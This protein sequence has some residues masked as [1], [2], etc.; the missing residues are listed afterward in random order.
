[1]LKLIKGLPPDV[2]GVEA[3]GK[4]T[5][6]DY[7]KV[8]I[9]AAEAKMVQGPIKML[10]V[11]GTDFGG[12]ELE[13]LWDDATFGFKHWRQFTHVAV[14][15]DSTWLRAAVTMFSPFFPSAVRLFKV[16]ELAAA[17]DWIAPTEERV[18]DGRPLP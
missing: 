14:V 8:L 4:V 7:H 15:T 9:P 10:Y 3:T 6:E 17:K 18:R 5:H 16:S 11:A 1:M 13:A 12:Y 2:L